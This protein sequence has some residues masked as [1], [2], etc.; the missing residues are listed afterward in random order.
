MIDAVGPE[1]PACRD[2]P[3]TDRTLRRIRQVTW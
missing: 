1:D 2:V 3:A